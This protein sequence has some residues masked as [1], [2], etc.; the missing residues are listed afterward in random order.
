MNGWDRYSG[1]GPGWGA[2]QRQDGVQVWILGGRELASEH[3]K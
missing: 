3:V 1:V 2:D